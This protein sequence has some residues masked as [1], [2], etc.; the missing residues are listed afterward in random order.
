MKF[1]PREYQELMLE[2]GTNNP[3]C[4][5]WADMGLGKSVVAA[6]IVQ[7]SLDSPFDVDRW[8]VVAPKLVA[9]DTWP[10]EFAK[11]DHLACIEYLQL[12]ASYFD[13]TV[14]SK[15]TLVFR[16]KKETKKRLLALNQPVHV[17]SWDFLPWLVRAM[18]SS[19]PYT[20]LILD[21]ATFAQDQSSLRHKALWSVQER[22]HRMIQ[23]TGSP[24]P[25]GYGQIYGQLRLMDG[26][27]RLGRTL[28]SYREQFM[29]PDK[30][31]WHTGQIYS[32]KLRPGAKERIDK[33]IADVCM[34]LATADWLDL[35]DQIVNDI[36]ITLPAKARAFYDELEEEMVA[37]DII[38]ASAGVLYGKLMQV[39]SGQVYGDNDK[40]KL[41]HSVKLDRLAEIIEATDGPILLAYNYTSE[42]DA[43]CR[44]FKFAQHVKDK[45][46]LNKFRAGEVRLMGMHPASGAHGL[47][48]LQLVCSVAVWF[49]ATINLE[50]WRQFNKRIHRSGTTADKVII[51]RLLAADTIE[52]E[53]AHIRLE[54]KASEEDALLE[55]VKGRKKKWA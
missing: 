9:E 43:I 37:E 8:L 52:E 11:W 25:N 22:A 39:A 20:G 51:H 23:L 30:R 27:K 7:Q 34:S 26:G 36:F 6:T 32:W 42:W 29:E 21:E 47:D 53:V 12:D 55:A 19:W 45:G 1:L 14:D 13:L 38:A 46:V 4:G 41:L 15:K 28:S 48:G 40:V 18:G 2:F 35:P 31:N 54:E 10:R 5:L 3:R 49:G 17:V 24:M 16:D 33:K 50:H 44:R